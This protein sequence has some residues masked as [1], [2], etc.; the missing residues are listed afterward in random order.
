[1]FLSPRLKSWH[2]LKNVV[3]NL[4]QWQA[5]VAA[6]QSKEEQLRRLDEVPDD[7]RKSVILHMRTVIAIKTFHENSRSK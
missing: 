3:K 1:M 6:G 7:M 2:V 4:G 5:Y